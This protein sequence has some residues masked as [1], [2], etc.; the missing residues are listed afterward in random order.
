MM[1]RYETKSIVDEI[2]EDLET[3]SSIK[4]RIIQVIIQQI[5]DERM[6]SHE[7]ENE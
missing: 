1:E 4:L 6:K 7:K 2:R 3:M 5:I